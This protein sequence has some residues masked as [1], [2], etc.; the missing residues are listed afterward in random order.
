MTR[1][2]SLNDS[3]ISNQLE[4]VPNSLIRDF[5]RMLSVHD[6]SH[7]LARKQDE[8]PH[9]VRDLLFVHHHDF[10]LFIPKVHKVAEIDNDF[11]CLRRSSAAT[12]RNC[13]RIW[14]H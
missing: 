14:T 4:A 1:C 11:S 3:D 10:K 6:A 13:H 5:Y 8:L 7:K 2:I 9:I 12:C